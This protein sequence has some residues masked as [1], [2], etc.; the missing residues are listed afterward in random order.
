MFTFTTDI[1]PGTINIVAS[2]NGPLEPE[3]WAKLA[4]DKI[5]YIG[6]QT[7][8][9]IRDQAIAYKQ[10]IQ[11]VVEYYIRQAVLSNEKHLLQRIK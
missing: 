9:P 8:G 2:N 3:Q 5:V 7:D 6:D 11:K 10:R 4:A 1:K